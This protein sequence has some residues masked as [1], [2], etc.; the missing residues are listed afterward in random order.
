MKDRDFQSKD[1]EKKKALVKYY[2]QAMG[3]ERFLKVLNKYANEQGYGIEHV[4]CTFANDF[5][6]WEDDYFGETGIA[7][8][9]DYPAVEKDEIV[10][11]NYETFYRYLKEA[12]IEYLERN[13]NNKEEVENLLKNIRERYNIIE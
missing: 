2:Y 5:E 3:D 8:Y 1:D 6:P 7:Y 10:I 12:S 11:L 4:W 9:F 13:S